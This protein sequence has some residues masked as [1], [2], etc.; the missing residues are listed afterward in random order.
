M[1]A[2]A[3]LL[4]S[5]YDAAVHTLYRVSAAMLSRASADEVRRV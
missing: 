5:P 3:V 2:E 4:P 1:V